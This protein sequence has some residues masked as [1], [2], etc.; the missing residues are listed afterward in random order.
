MRKNMKNVKANAT[1]G[2]NSTVGNVAVANEAITSYVIL[3]RTIMSN[4]YKICNK[5]IAS[6]PVQLFALDY[7]YQRPVSEKEIDALVSEWE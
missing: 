3:A 5:R 1:V 6:I 2:N 4:T 7:S